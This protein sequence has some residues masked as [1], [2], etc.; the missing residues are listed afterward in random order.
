MVLRVMVLM[1]LTVFGLTATE[2]FAIMQRQYKLRHG[3][4]SGIELGD[5]FSRFDTGGT[6]SLH[7][8]EVRSK[9]D[10]ILEE[11]PDAD[12]FEG[13]DSICPNLDAEAVSQ[14][15]SPSGGGG[16]YVRYAP[17]GIGEGSSLLN[18]WES[19]WGAKVRIFERVKHYFE[20]DQADEDRADDAS[21]A[22]S[23]SLP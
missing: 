9:T 17:G 4:S 6:T 20:G 3:D 13:E 10:A 5:D 2:C 23:A 22:G 14:L 7:V 19:A 18:R 12:A 1:K 8:P 11:D 21:D 15:P 16:G